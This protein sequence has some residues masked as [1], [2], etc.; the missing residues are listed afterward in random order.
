MNNI[1][2]VFLVFF[3][4]SFGNEV[5]RNAYKE[6]QKQTSTTDDSTK[7]SLYSYPIDGGS[8]KIIV[9][10]DELFN[11]DVSCDSLPGCFVIGAVKHDIN[12]INFRNER[13]DTTIVLNNPKVYKVIFDLGRGYSDGFRIYSNLDTNAWRFEF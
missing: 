11:G 10:D 2:L 1:K 12:V 4:Y 8:V 13:L 7:L 9:N 3:L 6:W 5:E